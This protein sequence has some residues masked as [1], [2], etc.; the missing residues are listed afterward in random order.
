[1][2]GPLGAPEVPYLV[3]R[4]LEPIVHLLWLFSFIEGEPS[5]LSFNHSH[6]SDFGDPITFVRRLEAIP[7]LLDVLQ[8][9]YFVAL[10]PTQGS[11]KYY[12]CLRVE[13][14]DLGDLV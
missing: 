8:P 12:N 10:L 7:N 14:L 11:K 13:M 4:H 2:A 9:L 3:H 1:M 6:L 5:K